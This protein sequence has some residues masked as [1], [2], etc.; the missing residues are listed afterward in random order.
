MKYV[1]DSS[2]GL[3]WVLPGPLMAK[4]LR[5]RADFQNKIHE[6][7]APETFIGETANG[8]IKAERQKVIA[9]GQATPQH[10]DIMSTAP[11]FFPF[12]PHV[13]RALAIASTTRAGF[14]DC[15]FVSLAEQEQCELV[16]ADDR[17][18]KN[19]G[20]QFPF[21]VSLTSLP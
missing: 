17:L 18:L 15:L 9:P 3:R 6:L 10:A 20:R 11:A 21:I 13:N 16:T 12:R 8:L 4:A 14:Y 1:L 2:V 19:L 5:L 7:I